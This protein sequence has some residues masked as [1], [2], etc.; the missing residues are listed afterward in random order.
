[1]KHYKQSFCSEVPCTNVNPP[2]WRLS[3]DGSG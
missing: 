3:G 1:M 2:Y